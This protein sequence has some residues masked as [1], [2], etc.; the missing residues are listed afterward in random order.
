MAKPTEWMTWLVPLTP[1]GAVGFQNALAGG[2]PGAI[3]FMIFDGAARAVPCAFVDA[4]HF[5]GVAGDAAVG[6][7]I[8]RVGE[9]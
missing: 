8:R 3:E 2:E 9:D 5:A 1:D 6:E 4:D 7:E